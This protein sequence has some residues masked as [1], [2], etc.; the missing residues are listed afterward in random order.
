M[1]LKKMAAAGL[2]VVVLAGLAGC[3]GSQDKAAD[4]K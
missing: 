2:S 4:K 1:N 3:G